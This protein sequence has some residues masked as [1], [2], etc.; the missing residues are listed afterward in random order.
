MNI[1]AK[2]K[3]RK[4]EKLAN[5]KQTFSGAVTLGALGMQRPDVAGE[6]AGEHPTSSP[7]LDKQSEEQGIKSR[8]D[9]P[10]SDQ[11]EEAAKPQDQKGEMPQTALTKTEG[12]ALEVLKPLLPAKESWEYAGRDSTAVVDITF[13]EVNDGSDDANADVD[14]G[15][16]KWMESCADPDLPLSI[17]IEEGITL[18]KGLAENY[19]LLINRAQKG[20]ADRAILLGKFFLALKDLVLQKG[21]QWIPWAEE[22]LPFIQERTR[23]KY[24]RLAS[25]NDCHRFSF[26]GLERLDMLCTATK[27]SKVDDPIGYLLSKY[28]IQFD[29]GSEENLGSFKNRVDSAIN[30]ERLSKEGFDP[31]FELISN[32]TSVGVSFD[33][34]LIKTM[35]NIRD[36][37]GSPEAYLQKLS[38]NQGKDDADDDAEK[39]IED[40]N[41]L[42]H[43][44]IVAVDF[45]LKDPDQALKVDSEIFSQLLSRILELQKVGN[46]TPKEEK[47]A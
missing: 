13:L 9:N 43:R 38:V 2:K 28:N 37:G 14:Y 20:L 42:A 15:I 36:C 31:N 3:A 6:T 1:Q 41:S 29:P 18:V 5:V 44:L 47:A 39:R 11:G 46:F 17:K 16:S 26:L 24:M 12:T 8:K 27:D 19:N 7:P 4:T 45:I 34:G 23:E 35:K 40:F 21:E 25:R 32:L 10:E 22:N 30:R 33:K